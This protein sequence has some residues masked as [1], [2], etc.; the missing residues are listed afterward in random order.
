MDEKCTQPDR[1]CE[2][3]KMTRVGKFYDLLDA[4]GQPPN[5]AT[6]YKNVFQR[7]QLILFNLLVLVVHAMINKGTLNITEIRC[8]Q[9]VK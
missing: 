1:E 5:V 3:K 2:L 7:L 6:C 8:F 9:V 4:T